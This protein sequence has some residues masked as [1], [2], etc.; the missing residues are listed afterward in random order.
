MAG[1]TST[2]FRAFDAF[3]RSRGNTDS[4]LEIGTC[5]VVDVRAEQPRHQKTTTLRATTFWRGAKLLSCT[6]HRVGHGSELHVFKQ[7]W[8]LEAGRVGRGIDQIGL[9]L[10]FRQSGFE[11]PPLLDNHCDLAEELCFFFIRPNLW[12][13]EQALVILGSLL[14]I[15]HLS[16]NKQTYHMFCYVPKRS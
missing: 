10:L 13:H 8:H 12:K 1:S 9:K 14:A 5:V 16:L 2:V 6:Q 15:R 7:R 3:D 4:Q 11:K